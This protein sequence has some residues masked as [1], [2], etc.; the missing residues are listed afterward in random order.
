MGKVR[1]RGNEGKEGCGIAARRL[2]WQAV[3]TGGEAENNMLHGLHGWIP[4]LRV[5]LRVKRTRLN[6]YT[7][8]LLK[9]CKLG[10]QVHV[11]RSSR[12]RSGHSTRSTDLTDFTEETTFYAQ[13]A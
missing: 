13:Y 6:T 7:L 11:R 5:Q 10:S 12:L 8:L 1:S 3:L 4:P 9:S 2:D